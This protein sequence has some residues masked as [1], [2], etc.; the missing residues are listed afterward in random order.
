[1]KDQGRGKYMRIQYT[2]LPFILI[3][4]EWEILVD[5]LEQEHGTSK[6]SHVTT[7]HAAKHQSPT[8]YALSRHTKSLLENDSLDE[9][10]IDSV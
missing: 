6:I 1:M 4:C 7:L 8:D 10:R 3:R 9:H 2:L 5:Y